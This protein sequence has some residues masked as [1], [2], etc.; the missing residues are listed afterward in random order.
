MLLGFILADG[1]SVNGW[2]DEESV[3][4]LG[5]HFS[6]TDDAAGDL[7]KADSVDL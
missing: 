6:K 1:I 3:S 2:G 4:T 7:R 5:Q